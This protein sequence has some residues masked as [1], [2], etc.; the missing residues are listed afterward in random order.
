MILIDRGA[1]QTYAP[2]GISDATYCWRPVYLN[3]MFT[4]LI[5]LWIEVLFI[6]MK[7]H[8]DDVNKLPPKIRAGIMQ[9]MKAEKKKKRAAL[10][11]QAIT[12]VLSTL[13]VLADPFIEKSLASSSLPGFLVT[14]LSNLAE[15]SASVWYIIVHVSD[16]VRDFLQEHIHDP[17]DHTYTHAAKRFGLRLY[18]IDIDND[19]DNDNLHH[20][21]DNEHL[22]EE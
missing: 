9:K 16:Y 6:A 4:G 1:C 8:D 7:N 12:A 21:D 13:L 5:V 22:H 3:L 10:E 20:F 14:V 17:A 11:Q 15:F 2:Q 18:L 19:E